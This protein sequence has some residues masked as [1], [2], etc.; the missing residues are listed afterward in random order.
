IERKQ[1]LANLYPRCVPRTNNVL[2]A[3]TGLSIENYRPIIRIGGLF[4]G[5]CTMVRTTIIAVLLLC[6]SSSVLAQSTATKLASLDVGYVLKDSDDR[7]TTYRYLLNELG[8]KYAETETTIADM[9]VNT[10]NR[11]SSIHGITLSIKT[12]MNDTNRIIQSSDNYP[13]PSYAE[14]A[15]AYL[16]LIGNGEDHSEATLDLRALAE[17]MGYR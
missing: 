5:R 16:T 2:Y 3:L 7:V 17:T 4:V 10:R 1:G 8:D 12:I 11:L 9:V 13:E 6:V 15:A 14:W